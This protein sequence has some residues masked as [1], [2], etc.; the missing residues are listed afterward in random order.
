MIIFQVFFFNFKTLLIKKRIKLIHLSFLLLDS[1]LSNDQDLKHLLP[2][3]SNGNDLYDKI[4]D[5]ILLCKI[6]N[7]SCPETID[8]RAINKKNLSLYNKIVSFF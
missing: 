1:N 4:K 5:G 2:I 7:Q 8:E 3:D 6:I